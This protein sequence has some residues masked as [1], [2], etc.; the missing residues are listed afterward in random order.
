MM[1]MKEL[2]EFGN[3]L[4]V[5]HLKIITG[6]SY[7]GL[8]PAHYLTLPSYSFDACLKYTDVKLQL[9]T[10]REMHLFIENSIRGGISVVSHRC[11]FV[12]L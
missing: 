9:L 7:Y 5:R 6:M 10:D 1:N 11:L 4:I 8:D 3:T 2:K 12:C